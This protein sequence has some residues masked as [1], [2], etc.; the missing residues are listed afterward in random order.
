[1]LL[2]INLGADLVQAYTGLVLM[3]QIFFFFRHSKIYERVKTIEQRRPTT[4]K[5]LSKESTLDS[6][7]SRPLRKGESSSSGATT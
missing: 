3:V 2:R 1:M 7:R 5:S 6:G 4:R